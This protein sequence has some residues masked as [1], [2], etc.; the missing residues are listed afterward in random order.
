MQI[1]PTSEGHGPSD[2]V[3]RVPSSVKVD[4][5]SGD[6]IIYEDDCCDDTADDMDDND[7]DKLVYPDRIRFI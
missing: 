1:A 2:D 5:T 3:A 7:M 4:C 6:A